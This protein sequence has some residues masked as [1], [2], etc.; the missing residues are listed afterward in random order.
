M[1]KAVGSISS[2]ALIVSVL[3]VKS[4]GRLNAVVTDLEQET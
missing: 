2:A 1:E 4:G 3:C